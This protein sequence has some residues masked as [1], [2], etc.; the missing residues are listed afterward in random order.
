VKQKSLLLLGSTLFLSFVNDKN[1]VSIL[2]YNA[3][4]AYCL[5][6]YFRIPTWSV[7][8]L[9]EI[10]RFEGALRHAAKQNFF[11]LII[12]KKT[13]SLFLHFQYFFIILPMLTTS[14]TL[15]ADAECVPCGR[16][17]KQ[18]PVAGGEE[19]LMRSGSTVENIYMIK[20]FT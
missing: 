13:F 16:T 6:G 8:G 20:A 17:P 18:K 4:I 3:I 2:Q 1:R 11:F 12:F 19:L 15:L 14:E 10:H 7:S 9:K 5:L